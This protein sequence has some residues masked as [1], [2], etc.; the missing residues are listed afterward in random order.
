M[1]YKSNDIKIIYELNLFW[2]Q[3]DL[4]NLKL[5]QITKNYLWAKFLIQVD[6]I[7]LYIL[8]L[9]SHGQIKKIIW[10]LIS[11]NYMNTI[12]ILME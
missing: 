11:I 7:K 5:N 8:F 9:N 12:K 4:Y 2:N 10:H 1:L 3:I 6:S